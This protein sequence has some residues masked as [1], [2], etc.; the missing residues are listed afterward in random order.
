MVGVALD[1]AT[2]ELF[3]KYRGSGVGGPHRWDKYWKVLEWS[4]E[5]FGE[6]KAGIHLIAG[7]GETERQMVE[8]IYRAHGMGAKTHLFSFFPEADSLLEDRERP[9]L[10]SYR[11]IQIAAYLINEKSCTPADMEFSNGDIISFN[12][13]LEEIIS[14]ACRNQRYAYRLIKA[15]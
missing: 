11:K 15:L 2:E 1:T 5:A 7:L 4:V 10:A 3:K 8:T 6:F 14:D 12:R 9:E 13:D